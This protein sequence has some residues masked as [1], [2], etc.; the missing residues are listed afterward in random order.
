MSEI[1]LVFFITLKNNFL[2]LFFLFLLIFSNFLIFK[3][4]FRVCFVL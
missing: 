1:I 2:L 4:V 3:I